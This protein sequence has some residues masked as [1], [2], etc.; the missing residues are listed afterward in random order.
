MSRNGR[1]FGAFLGESPSLQIGFNQA[2]GHIGGDVNPMP[3]GQYEIAEHQEDAIKIQDADLMRKLMYISGLI[4]VLGIFMAY[5]F[6][7]KDRAAADRLAGQHPLVI[8][9]AR[10]QILGR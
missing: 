1:G 5:L 7:L 8:R 4:S 10:T 6:H 9:V 3:F 2:I